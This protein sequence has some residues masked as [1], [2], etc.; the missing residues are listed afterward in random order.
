M[1]WDT[2]V[3]KPTDS[4]SQEAEHARNKFLVTW[5]FM[6]FCYF[7][8]G[9]KYSVLDIKGGKKALQFFV[10]TNPFFL[11]QKSMSVAAQERDPEPGKSY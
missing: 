9:D 2:S 10:G 1:A 5:S 11:P 7:F 4:S 8:S 3:W 6:L